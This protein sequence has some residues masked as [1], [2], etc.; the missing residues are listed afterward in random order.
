MQHRMLM[1]TLRSPQG[2]GS[3]I[4]QVVFKINQEL[5]IK[6]FTDAWQKVIKHHEIMRLGFAWKNLEQLLQHIVPIDR[7]NKVNIEINDWSRLSKPEISEFFDMF[8]QADRRLGFS[9][10]KPPLYRIALLKTDANQ[11]TC[12]WSLHHIIADG[13][14]MVSILR[15]LFLLY[16]NPNAKIADPGSF[17]KYIGWLNQQ[18]VDLNAKKFWKK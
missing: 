14:S 6:R 8:L 16:H 9:L 15:D 7:A 3:Y 1:E 11:Y 4:E 5:D 18:Q 17:K 2:A 12:V 10:A 13:R